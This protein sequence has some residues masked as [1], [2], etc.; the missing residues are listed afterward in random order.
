MMYAAISLTGYILDMLTLYAYL[1]GILKV[2]GRRYIFF[3]PALL[4]VESLLYVN[5]TIIADHNSNSTSLIITTILS[6]TGIKHCKLHPD[7][8]NLLCYHFH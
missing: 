6:M 2:R 3:Y 7:K 5:D 4:I 1:N 8:Q